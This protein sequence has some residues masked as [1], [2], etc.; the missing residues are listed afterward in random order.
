MRFIIRQLLTRDWDVVLSHTLREGNSYAVIL[1][2]MGP[3]ANALLVITSTPLKT[4]TRPLFEDA[5]GVITPLVL[6]I[7]SFSFLYI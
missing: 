5:N 1:A 3:V 7:L 6:F 4:L 2:K